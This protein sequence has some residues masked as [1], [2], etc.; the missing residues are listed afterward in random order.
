M[1]RLQK[2]MNIGDGKETASAKIT[3]FPP[4]LAA[5]RNSKQFPGYS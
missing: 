1:F 5:I 2:V 3:E 4:S